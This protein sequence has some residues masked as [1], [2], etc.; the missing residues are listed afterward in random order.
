M[1]APEYFLGSPTRCAE[2]PPPLS[3]PRLNVRSH[4]LPAATPCSLVC[5]TSKSHPKVSE[6]S[7]VVA[8]PSREKENKAHGSVA[9]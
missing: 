4:R 6:R 1:L 8:G 9:F 5:A 7:Q 2:T 3:E